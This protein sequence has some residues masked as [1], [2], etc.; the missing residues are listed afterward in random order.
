MELSMIILKQIVLMFI[1]MMIGF[2]LY[3]KKFVTKQGS[4]ELGLILLYVILPVVIVKAYLVTFSAELL[5]GLALSFAAS[6]LV[7][8][9]SMLLSRIV[10]RSK[11]P[12]EQFS[13]AFS[14]AGFIGIPLVE[15]TFN[16]SMAVF[17]VSSFVA[18][19]NILQWTYGIV[20]MTGKRDSIAPKKITTNPIV[21]SF[22]VGIILFFLPVELPEVLN[23]AV[24]AV[25]SMNAPVAMII[26]GTY[27]AQMKLRELF[28]DR[29]VYLCA[30]M[31]LIVIPLATAAVLALIPGNEMLKMSVLIVA[32]TP[33][34]SN[35]AIF[36]QMEDMD[37][38]QAVKDICLSTLLCIVTIPLVV[39]A[40]GVL[41]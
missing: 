34:G 39:S 31:R 19:L 5:R 41:F 27:L 22:I 25:S 28:T 24:A 11:Y 32:A 33:V 1:Y 13:S 29:M 10:F 7:L 3:K 21:I 23:S 30:V 37:Y 17:Y 15:M 12:I 36:A 2:L 38:T 20:V 9:L 6:L 4:K 35:V 26:L 18:L 16:D 40:A 8:L 14:N